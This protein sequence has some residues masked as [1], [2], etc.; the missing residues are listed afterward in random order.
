M[1]NLPDGVDFN[2]IQAAIAW[3][4]VVKSISNDA[5][6]MDKKPDEKLN[7][8]LE[9]YKKAFKSIWRKSTEPA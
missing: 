9:A 1:G 7:F 4:I 3:E 6:F 5:D 8:L 2:S